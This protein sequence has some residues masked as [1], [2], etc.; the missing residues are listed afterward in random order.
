MATYYWRGL[1]AVGPTGY[2][3]GNTA[4]WRTSL[5][6]STPAAVFPFGGDTVIFGATAIACCLVGGMTNGYWLGY[7]GNAGDT[8]WSGDITMI[9]EG[10]YGATLPNTTNLTQLGYSFGSATGG[11][12]LKVNKLYIGTVANNAEISIDNFPA[13]SNAVALMDGVTA[14]F[15][16]TG[17]WKEIQVERGS[18]KSESLTCDSI[19]VQGFQGFRGATYFT[20]TTSEYGVGKI[21]LNN[22]SNIGSVV[23]TTKATSDQAVINT[24]TKVPVTN[25]M[26]TTA[27]GYTFT[28]VIQN[29][30]PAGFERDL[31][32][33]TRT[34]RYKRS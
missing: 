22:P 18:L 23:F 4:N 20:G 2:E 16:A 21:E 6:S 25:L 10:S 30:R 24:P 19:I 5:T 33:I 17:T 15:F 8:Y 27:A 11:L 3:W 9:I 28:T 7:T 13:S 1:T 29:L 14:T 31:N 26:G 32:R 34:L 12:N